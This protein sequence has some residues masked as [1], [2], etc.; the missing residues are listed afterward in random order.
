MSK[1][2]AEDGRAEHGTC[3]YGGTTCLVYTDRHIVMHVTALL[4]VIIGTVN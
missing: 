4:I 2:A 1:L 3:G